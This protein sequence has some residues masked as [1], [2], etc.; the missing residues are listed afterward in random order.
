MTETVNKAIQEFKDQLD[1]K[2]VVNN[3]V[4]LNNLWKY[5][6]LTTAIEIIEDVNDN[7]DEEEDDSMVFDSLIK[8]Q[9]NLSQLVSEIDHDDY[10]IPDWESNTDY[11]EYAED[12]ISTAKELLK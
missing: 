7:L 9:G 8:K 5:V 3:A 1:K 11:H 10:I 6:R 2:Y 12:V 4:P